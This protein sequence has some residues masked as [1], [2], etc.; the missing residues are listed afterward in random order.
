MNTDG[1]VASWRVFLRP[2]SKMTLQD[3]LSPGGTLWYSFKRSL[4]LFAPDFPRPIVLA[5]FDME[6]GNSLIA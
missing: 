3:L 1:F 6:I 2:L 5:C 4:H